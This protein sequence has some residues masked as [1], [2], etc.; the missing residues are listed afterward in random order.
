MDKYGVH[1][2]AERGTLRNFNGFKVN[3]KS[4]KSIS[5]D[6]EANLWNNADYT[7]HHP[8]MHWLY[9]RPS[10]HHSTLPL[11]GIVHR[12][13]LQLILTSGR[14]F[15]HELQFFPPEKRT[16]D[17]LNFIHG[18]SLPLRGKI[19]SLSRER[20]WDSVYYFASPSSRDR[21]NDYNPNLSSEFSPSDRPHLPICTCCQL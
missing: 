7:V 12:G 13:S 9:E 14:L 19:I 16:C 4:I 18:G 2:R 3:F 6:S 11:A 5:Y 10:F 20:N 15:R 1:V 8:S 17:E 21:T